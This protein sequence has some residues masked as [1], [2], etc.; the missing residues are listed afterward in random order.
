M[1][2]YLI[3]KIIL[4]YSL[5]AV[6]ALIH[7]QVTGTENYVQSISY[8]DSTKVS[9]PAKK[10]IQ[11]VQYFDGLGRPRQIVN[12]KASPQGKDL[13]I[14]VAYDNFGRQAR[15]YF[16][17]PQSGTT[18]G[19]I[20]QQNSAAV[21][22]P[23]AD[24]GNIYAGEKIYAEKQFENSPLS[25]INQMIQPGTAW[26][27]KPIGYTYGANRQ[28]DQVKKYETVT[29]WDTAG[30]MYTSTVSQ[31]SFYAQGQLYKNTTA[32][33]DGNKTI[34]FKNSQGQAVLVRK[35]LSTT[36]NADTYYIYNEYNQLSYVIPPAAAMVGI[37]GTVLDNLCYQY[38]YD[39]RY[40]LAEKKLPGKGWEFM[41]YDKQDRLILTQ[42]AVLRTTTNNFGAKG[43]L[44]TKYDQ[45]DRIVYT[46]FFSNTATR[47]AMQTAVNNMASNAANNE[48]RS[49]TT[50]F[51]PQDLNVYYTKNAFPTGSMTVLTINYYDTYPPSM[52][53]E[54]PTS[55]LGQK[56]LKQ[57]GEGTLKNTNGL[58]LSSF[59]KNV[60]DVGW[61]RNYS[62]YDTKGRVIG[63]YS[64]NYLA[65]HTITETEYDF[66]GAVKQTITK[67][68]RSRT[69]T[70]FQ[71]KERFVY[72]GQNRVL[73]HYHQV[74]TYAEELLAENTYNE[75]GQLTN[76]KTGNTSGTPLQSIDY[77]YNIRGWITKVNNPADLGEKLFGYE[78]KYENPADAA[79]GPAKYNGNI[80]EFD[81][82]TSTGDFLRRYAYTYDA[83]NRLKSGSYREPFA[84]AP[85]TDGYNERLTYDLNGNIQTLKRLQ[86]LAN[87]PALI[88][89]LKYEVYEGNR[90][91]KVTDINTNPSG[92]PTGGNT[93]SYDV[94]GNM[95]DH[96]DKGITAIS[97]NFLNLPKEVKFAEGN[98]NLQFLYRADGIKLKKTFIYL[99]TKSGLMMR[100]DTDY[101]DGF[102]YQK[103]GGG[104]VTLQFF[105]TAEGYYDFQKKRYVYNYEDHLGN[106]RLAYYQSTSVDA[107]VVDKEINYYPFGMEY[108]GFQGAN[109][110][111]QSYTYGYN[112]KERQKETG[113]ND[114]GARM[115]MPDLGRWSVMDE[116]AEK[117]RRFSPYTYALDNP[118]MFIDPD[119]RE[120]E[121][122]CSWNDVKAFGRGA[123]NTTKGMVSGLAQANTVSVMV[124]A[125]KEWTKVYNA[126]E[127]GGA[128]AAGNQYI[129]SVYET[130][131]AKAIVQTSKGVAKGDAESI[132]SAVVIAGALVGTHKIGAK[133]NSKSSIIGDLT[134]NEA[135][136]IQTE[137]N[138]AGR[139]LEI[140]GS[141][142]EGNRRNVG[143]NLPIGK[144]AGTRS[145]IDYISPPSSIQYFDQ[146]KLPSID[147][148]TGIIPGYGNT[149]IG[150]VVRFEPGGTN[151]T[152]NRGSSAP[153]VT[154]LLNNR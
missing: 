80:S 42:D 41:V 43:W 143:S 71:V 131:G 105:P 27:T 29:S 93:I 151:K 108:E 14:A 152:T 23:V 85:V 2:K 146:Y 56:V 60:E 69:D 37:D 99:A 113:W 7:A 145:D 36:E 92:Y 127:K 133:V 89:D 91:K 76:K 141:A 82:R 51:I 33:E 110:D 154:P 139:P 144:G 106:I 120:A 116:L 94:N 78:L 26:S 135:R 123:W 79:S 48:T 121:R 83:L 136:Q 50:P 17:V 134:K 96:L 53:A 74:G 150:P 153:I 66:G 98:N 124:N 103:E 64:M 104:A 138:K 10:R 20:Y 44:F 49:D 32:D 122:C 137:V 24:P 88:D 129:N 100:N 34:E 125:K 40:R 117:S 3:S 102:Q 97:Y 30:K 95:T 109:T 16:P 70:E 149:N 35:V 31:S 87:T 6:S 84:T 11:T 148:N 107:V 68:K 63:T 77:A 132:G 118:I 8:L 28:E 86:P 15:E 81:W 46:G 9:D 38:R 55:I 147:P 72:D 45:F 59:I 4:L 19:A 111:L 90:L 119:G 57:P 75:I 126:Y 115:Y 101:L 61:T 22:Y 140:V 112:G 18:G 128:K 130:S 67:H 21:P 58:A 5:F 39:S 142:A 62:W 73:K 52:A 1:K 114:Y 25:R 13:V 54:I 12:V 65:G 47:I